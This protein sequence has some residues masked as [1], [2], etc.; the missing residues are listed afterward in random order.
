M[1][2]IC[3]D[4][5]T[6]TGWAK[7][8]GGD[9]TFGSF[10]MPRGDI[11]VGRFLAVFETC[12]RQ[13]IPA[14]VEPPVLVVFEMPWVGP[15]T[16]QM[17][18]RKLMGLAAFLEWY[19]RVKCFDP[20]ECC[21]VNNAQVRKHFIGVGRAGRAELKRLT[22][23][24]CQARGLRPANDDEAD[25]IAVLDFAA[26]VRGIQLPW[27]RRASVSGC[28]VS[29]PYAQATSGTAAR[30]DILNILKR[31][32]C[33]TV[34]FM[35]DFE[36]HTL[37]LAFKWRGRQIQ[38][39]ASAQGWANYFLR[40]SPWSS[41]RNLTKLAYENRALEQ[42]MVAVNSILRDWIKG[43]VTAIE[44]GI[45]TFEHVFMP[46]MLTADGRSV[47]EKVTDPNSGL[48]PPPEPIE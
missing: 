44:T 4:L 10:A 22:M 34:G 21:E 2:I 13:I 27:G 46:Y 19:C 43:Q 18:A 39:R 17:T 45:L 24:A 26:S 16:H 15:K 11:D 36:T 6:Q 41:R 23:D 33:Q 30:A 31:F 1:Q 14:D 48:L 9:V 40:Q 28:A 7:L 12:I 42:G 25:A 47:A 37:I 32:G 38:L 3:F 20:V 5:A 8:A 35:D 29:V